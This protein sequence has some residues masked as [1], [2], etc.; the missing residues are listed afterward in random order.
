[1]TSSSHIVY[2]FPF[3]ST[4]L[5]KGLKKTSECNPLA[6]RSYIVQ[7]LYFSC[8]FI[9]F[10]WPANPPFTITCINT[11]PW[12]RKV[13]FFHF[14]YKELIV[15]LMF[16]ICELPAWFTT[17][18]RH[19]QQ[20]QVCTSSLGRLRMQDRFNN[21]VRLQQGNNEP[22][23]L[24]L[25]CHCRCSLPVFPSSNVMLLFCMERAAEGQEVF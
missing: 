10:S 2:H 22:V 11:G 19:K 3:I 17:F 12:T 20:R 7:C 8:F 16:C 15:D 25:H 9:F 4:F 5:F 18:I 21:A 6:N 13:L 24:L 1:M 23:K 14:L